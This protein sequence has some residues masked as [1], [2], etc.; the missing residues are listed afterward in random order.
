[1]DGRRSTLAFGATFPDARGVF[2]T[3]EDLRAAWSGPRRCLL[4][5]SGS[6]G[7]GALAGVSR[8]G[9][10]LLATGGGRALY[11]NRPDRAETP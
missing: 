4:V 1:V 10:H 5:T 2:W 3:A 9:V 11:S 8:E 6:A 7:R